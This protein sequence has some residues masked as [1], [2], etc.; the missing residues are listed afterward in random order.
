[1]ARH[2]DL[3]RSTAKLEEK[4]EDEAIAESRKRLGRPKAGDGRAAQQE[5]KKLGSEEALETKNS[6]EGSEED[7]NTAKGEAGAPKYQQG[8][9]FRRQRRRGYRKLWICA[10]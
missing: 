1:M 5:E 2:K 10:S 8:R 4:E 7:E 6:G 3:L 9:R